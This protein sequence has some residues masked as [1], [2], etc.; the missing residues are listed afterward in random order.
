MQGQTK[1]AVASPSG[2]LHIV[3]QLGLIGLYKGATACLA[4]DVPF[5]A[6]Y[7]PAY[8]HLKKDVF[9]EGRNGKKLGYGEA[10]AAAAIA[11]MPAAFLTTPADVIKTRLQSEARKG[12]THYKGVSD[13]FRKICEWPCERRCAPSESGALT[14]GLITLAVAEEGPRALYKGGPARVLRSSP[15]FGVTMVAYE[16]F[17][18]VAPF[19]EPDMVRDAI[20]PT[21]EAVHRTR[22][23]NALRGKPS[24]SAHVTGNRC[25]S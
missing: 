2:A 16:Q 15:Q 8:W 6:I 17:K 7:F 20:I 1:A 19:P 25:G 12:E 22:A 9:H 3:K 23:R 18:K 5:S 21:S 13:A 10:L 14:H 24:E 4:R 11:G